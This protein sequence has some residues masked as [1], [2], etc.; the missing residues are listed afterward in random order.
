MTFQATSQDQ[1]NINTIRTLSIDAVQKANSGHPGLP[2]GAAPMA[3]ILW[4]YFLNQNPNQ[5]NWPNR[6]RFIL[7]AGHGSM[8]LY[9]LLHLAGYPLTIEDLKNFR[10]WQSKTPGHPESFITPGV[11]ATT[12]P[13]GQ[14]TANAVGM[15][16][17]ERAL[18]HR[19]NR[20]GFPIVDHFTYAIVSDGDLMEG[21]SFEAASLAGHLKLGKLIYLYDANDI[22]LDGP[23][24]LAYSEDVT[25][26]FQSQGWQVLMVENGDSDL[27]GLH[28]ALTAA[29]ADTT[30]PSLIVVKTTIGFG[31]PN[32][33]GS[34][35]AHGSPLGESEVA[36][37][38]AQLKWPHQ[39]PFTVPD[40]VRDHFAARAKEG[41]DAQNRWEELFQAYQKSYPD[42][43]LAWQNDSEQMLPSGW[44]R[45]LPN[46]DAG[47]TIATRAA[48][49][50]VLNA[51]AETIPN[52]IG[53]DA[54]LSC[55]T[56]TRI[57][58]ES[59]FEGQTGSGR[60]IRFGVREH[61]MGAIANGMAY[62]GG[63]RPFTAT[64]F[65]FADYMRPAMRLA[66]LS[67]L[68]V[69]FVF[70]HDSI[71]VGEDGPTHQPVEHLASLRAMPNMAVV[72]PGDAE[73]TREAWRYAM[74]RTQGPTT[75]VF[76]RQKLPTFDRS[77]VA[78]ADGLHRGAY[79]LAEAQGELSLIL[80]ATGSEVSLALESRNKLQ[81]QG[82]GTRVVSMPCWEAFEE[83]EASYRESVLP[84]SVTARLA[85]ET[86]AGFG[87]ER[88]VGNRG[89][90]ITMDRFGASAPGGTLLTNFGFAV[91]NVIEQAQ[92]ILDRAT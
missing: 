11:E 85:L 22:S 84:A 31:S 51:L 37:T 36:A 6:D 55:S 88:W 54:D 65:C 15:A 73:E 72:R 32:K 38:K 26:R 39:E 29:R 7:S 47:Q 52:L 28:Q 75:L 78:K 41:Q 30:R 70:T 71:G 58:E 81:A 43:A 8:L 82:I 40:S 68:P 45:N 44:D 79:I 4:R 80:L 17:A 60:N 59:D 33:A 50:Q 62:H 83:Q 23:L 3:Y 19:F 14:G 9:S 1:L 63:L 89:G 92:I 24:S 20:D 21:I 74:Q 42:L 56:K 2:L 13:L 46:W 5:P 53:G 18:A 69:T 12:G 76:S 64:F 66:A 91:T 90:M 34:S 77:K 67:K 10:Q 86:G 16:I 25:T 87:W 49:G 57:D 61:A 35:G 27:A 48:S